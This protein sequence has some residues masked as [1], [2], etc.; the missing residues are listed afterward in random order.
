RLGGVEVGG[1][2][3]VATRGRP[4][5]VVAA[6]NH[7]RL[8]EGLGALVELHHH[9]GEV[10]GPRDQPSGGGGVGRNPVAIQHLLHRERGQG[11]SQR[12]LLQGERRPVSVVG[13]AV[14]VHHR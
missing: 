5:P 14:Y 1:H 4:G 7:R 2:G 9:L 6:V 11:G 13:G 12:D 8:D 10:R 3:R